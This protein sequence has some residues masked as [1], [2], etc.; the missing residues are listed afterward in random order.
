MFRRRQETLVV[1]TCVTIG[2]GNCQVEEA[3]LLCLD[4]QGSFKMADKQEEKKTS[5]A[6][7]KAQS[8]GGIWED[9]KE[10]LTIGLMNAL[11]YITAAVKGK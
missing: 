8:G 2:Q 11:I 3:G 7:T 9:T 6:D 1:V 5:A 4:S 10:G